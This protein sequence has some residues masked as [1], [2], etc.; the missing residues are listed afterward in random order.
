MGLEELVEVAKAHVFH[1]HAQRLFV[2]T[3]TQHTH[4][5]GVLQLRHDLHLLVEVGSGNGEFIAV[6][7]WIQRLYNGIGLVLAWPRIDKV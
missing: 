6:V 4:D 1:N 3:H 7:A 5:V 2:L